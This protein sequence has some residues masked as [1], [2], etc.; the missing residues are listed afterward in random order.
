MSERQ[1]SGT[2]ITG[3]L[4]FIKKSKGQD[5][6]TR[7]LRETN[8]DVI[9]VKNPLKYPFEYQINV[10]KWIQKN[11][12]DDGVVRAGRFVATDLGL[13]KLLAKLKTME[14]MMEI[15]KDRY[16]KTIYFGSIDLEK[17]E[18]NHIKI[19]LK[20]AADDKVNCLAWKGVFK[21]L[22]DLSGNKTTVI[23]KKCIFRGD[24]VCEYSVKW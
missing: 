19:T 5:G 11:Q 23:E 18:D 20:D 3:Y 16:S 21:G 24:K 14:G 4:N 8:L 15:A 1:V 17:V 12:G 22:G 6:L 13:L 10:L 7:C 2:T 9:E